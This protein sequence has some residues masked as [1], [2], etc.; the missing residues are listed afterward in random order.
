MA[1]FGVCALKLAV[2]LVVQYPA[3]PTAME[4]VTKWAMIQSM[5]EQEDVLSAF[6]ADIEHLKV[7]CHCVVEVEIEIWC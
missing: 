2:R 3:Q 6:W 5:N 4:E 7:C 1:T